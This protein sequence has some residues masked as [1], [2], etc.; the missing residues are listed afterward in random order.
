[1]RVTNETIKNWQNEMKKVN[2]GLKELRKDQNKRIFEECKLHEK[3]DCTNNLNKDFHQNYK[4]M[5]KSNEWKKLKDWQDKQS[6]TLHEL[7]KR[8]YWLQCRLVNAF[9]KMFTPEEY[10][11][12]DKAHLELVEF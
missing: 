4:K 9:K 6:D 1:M 2:T 5:I 10:A 11:K 3:F 12:L 7:N 8:E